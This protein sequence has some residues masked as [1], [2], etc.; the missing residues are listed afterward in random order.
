MKKITALLAMAI[1][2]PLLCGCE[3]SLPF[4]QKAEF[5]EKSCVMN[6]KIDCGELSAAAEVI[7][8]GAGEWEF[9]FTDP[10]QIM[11]L[12]IN[13]DSEGVSASLGGL[14]VEVE[15]SAV[16]NMLP[17]VIA[18]AVDSLSEL[19]AESI[20]ENEGV[21]TMKTD[22]G[23]G[24]VVVTAQ[25]DSCDLISLKCPYQRLAVYFSDVREIS[26]ESDEVRIVEEM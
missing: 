1:A 5:E 22:C 8:R 25:K 3:S 23:D 7:R 26:A 12:V 18:N 10:P 2:V 4:S 13:L 24:S 11:G 6:A 9:S 19:P 14:S 17:K 20:E 15:P 21:L 16:Y